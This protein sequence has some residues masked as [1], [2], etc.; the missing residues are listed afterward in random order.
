MKPPL[1]NC[2]P[3]PSDQMQHDAI[4]AESKICDQV[5]Q[6]D[7][8]S[9]E[10]STQVAPDEPMDQTDAWNAWRRYRY[11]NYASLALFASF[12]FQFIFCMPIL[13]PIAKRL[14]WNPMLAFAIFF[15]FQQLLVQQFWI[16]FRCPR[17]GNRFHRKYFTYTGNKK[18]LHC[19]FP[20]SP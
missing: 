10:F 14:D 3:D 15:V 17:C 6:R 1:A 2:E 20:D 4:V 5:Q 8:N 13:A 16:R 9:P 11:F 12:P 18:C 7:S 19:S